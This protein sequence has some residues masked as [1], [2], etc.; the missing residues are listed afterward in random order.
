MHRRELLCFVVCR[1]ALLS[2][3]M[4][5]WVLLCGVVVCRVLFRVVVL[6]LYVSCALLVDCC[7]CLCDIVCC[8]ALLCVLVLFGLF[9]GVLF[10]VV[11]VVVRCCVYRGVWLVCGWCVFRVVVSGC[12]LLRLVVSWFSSVWVVVRLCVWLCDVVRRCRALVCVVVCRC[13]ALLC[14]V[15]S[16]CVLL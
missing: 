7:A 16:C 8:C 2:V 6:L 5:Q 13:C 11:C 12:V 10:C 4:S 1:C 14:V 3:V 15:V 9:C